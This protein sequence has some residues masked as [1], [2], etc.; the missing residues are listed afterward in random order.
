MILCKPTRR[1]VAVVRGRAFV[2]SSLK[3]T[4]PKLTIFIDN[5]FVQPEESFA[6]MTGGCS[7]VYSNSIITSTS[8]AAGSLKY[9]YDK[10]KG[11]IAPGTCCICIRTVEMFDL[12]LETC[13]YAC[14]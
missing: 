6:S 12:D 10:A 3:N 14:T 9:L 7:V 2:I 4:P 13:R 11:N 5:Q 1:D 8:N